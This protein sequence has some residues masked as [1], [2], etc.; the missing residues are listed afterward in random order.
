M[1]ISS[2]YKFYLILLK[3]LITSPLEYGKNFFKFNFISSNKIKFEKRTRM[4][5]RENKVAVCIHEWGG[6]KGKRKKK[7][8]NIKEFECGLDYQLLRFLNYKGKYEIDPTV[9]VSESF[10]M[11]KKI[12]NVKVME[13]SN[14]GMDFSGYS[15]FYDS[16]KN[17]ENQYVILSNS[18]VN[19]L[20]VEFIDEY[21]DFFK[22]NITIGMMGVSVN[23]KIYQSL[24][25]NNFNPHLQ[26]FFLITTIDVLREVVELCGDFPGKGIDHKLLLIREGEVKLSN[27]ILNLGY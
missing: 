11:T 19:K 20:Q 26:S 1:G 21:L 14:K 22:E 25:K 15:A 4:P 6:Y 18:S 9:T 12:E 23:S 3:E 7:I 13:V 16:I 27:I 24:I 17:F 8:K 10:L 5:I 2:K